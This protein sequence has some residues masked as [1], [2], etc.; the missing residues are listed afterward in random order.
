MDELTRRLLPPY[1]SA[2]ND[3]NGEL[4]MASL[5]V[6]QPYDLERWEQEREERRRQESARLERAAA[7]P[8]ARVA[9]TPG[10]AAARP[11]GSAGSVQEPRKVA[12]VTPAAAGRS[13]R[14]RQAGIAEVVAA[15]EA[16][17]GEALDTVMRAVSR[18]VD[19]LT[20]EES[21]P[22]SATSGSASPINRSGSGRASGVVRF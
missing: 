17:D 7:P 3:R 18:R 12:A 5:Q 2:E 21:G 14:P 9:V 10:K 16:A 20:A 11:S 4:I 22:R 1:G 13:Q 19:Q 8:A 6:P 15:V